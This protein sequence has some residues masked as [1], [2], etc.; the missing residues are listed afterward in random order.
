MEKQPEKLKNEAAELDEKRKRLEEQILEFEP[1]EQA[2][3]SKVEQ[4]TKDLRAQKEQEETKLIDLNGR[5]N[6]CKHKVSEKL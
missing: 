1:Q 3:L 5:V 4:E 2:G 6:D